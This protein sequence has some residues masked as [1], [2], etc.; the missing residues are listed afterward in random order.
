MLDFEDYSLTQ[1]AILVT[2]LTESALR[3]SIEKLLRNLKVYGYSVSEIPGVT[4]RVEHFGKIVSG[5]IDSG[6]IDSEQADSE[7]IESG[8]P[9]V[10][11]TAAETQVENYATTNMEVRAVVSPEVSN[12]ILVALREQQRE[13]AVLVYRQKIEALID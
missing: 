11:E 1:P 12:V 5:Q 13:F 9:D 7:E 8:Q 2:I 10:A 4:K 6:Q 3:A